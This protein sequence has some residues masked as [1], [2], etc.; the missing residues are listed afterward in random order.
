[1]KT[2]NIILFY[3]FI[4][5]G[6]LF[7]N[8]P[9]C[10]NGNIVGLQNS[11]TVKDTDGNVYNTVTIGNQTWMVENLK[12]I[13]YNDGNAIPLVTDSVT[14]INTLSD[15]YCLYNNNVSYGLIYG[16]L[17]NASAI[18]NTVHQLAPKGWHVPSYSEWDTLITYLGGSLL[19][20]NPL[21]ESNTTHWASPNTGTNTSGFTAL[22]GGL[23]HG[24]SI[25]FIPGHF[26]DINYYGGWWTSTALTGGQSSFYMFNNNGTLDNINSTLNCGLSVRCIKNS[27]SS[28]S[29]VNTITGKDVTIYPNPVKDNLIV[30]IP[31]LSSQT[32]IEIYN[33]S[34]EKVISIIASDVSTCLNMNEYAAGIYFIRIISPGKDVII[35]RIVVYK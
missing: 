26:Q 14:W 30:S 7:F 20:G 33:L 29:A 21:K 23:R 22:P 1:M 15:A 10:I 27:N 5:S 35:R 17:Y 18:D 11:T 9:N 6:I 31:D 25:I 19:A 24:T 32:D 13:H 3:Y 34:G 2:Q 28:P 12:T 16:A 4:V 8:N